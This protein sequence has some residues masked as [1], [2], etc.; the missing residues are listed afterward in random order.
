MF[1]FRRIAALAAPALLVPALLGATVAAQ[2]PTR[3]TGDRAVCRGN[4]CLTRDDTGV[5]GTHNK[6]KF[7]KGVHAYGGYWTIKHAGTVGEKWPFKYH[8]FDARWEHKEVVQIA[9][10]TYGHQYAAGM[11][12][13][14]VLVTT[15]L[16]PTNGSTYWVELKEKDN[17]WRFISV[18]GT[19]DIFLAAGG[20]HETYFLEYIGSGRLAVI[21]P[22]GGV[23]QNMSVRNTG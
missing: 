13:G 3:V 8:W 1:R 17:L 16:E 15:C 12:G 22:N 14:G 4:I 19:D 5:T 9:S 11:C 7:I 20:K 10:R 2:Q 18:K 23:R 6:L 21:G